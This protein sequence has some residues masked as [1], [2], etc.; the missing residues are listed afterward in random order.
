MDAFSLISTILSTFFGLVACICIGVLFGNLYTKVTDKQIK[1]IA[2]NTVKEMEAWYTDQTKEITAMPIPTKQKAI[3]L[4][5]VHDKS[6][7]ITYK[8]SNCNSFF[9]EHVIN[10]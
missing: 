5:E 1:N 2:S 9:C 8:C 3:L 7:K 4:S 10:D 6:K